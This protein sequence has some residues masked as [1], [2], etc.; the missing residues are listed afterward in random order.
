MIINDKLTNKQVSSSGIQKK[1]NG[2]NDFK[3]E[4]KNRQQKNDNVKP[5]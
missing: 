4:R 2:K 5:E 3:E 1:D